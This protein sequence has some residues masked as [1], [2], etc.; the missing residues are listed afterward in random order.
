M[1]HGAEVTHL[2]AMNL[3]AEVHNH[4]NKRGKCGADMTEPGMMWQSSAPSST[5]SILAPTHQRTGIVACMHRHA[6]L[7]CN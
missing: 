5:P 6:S 7:T 2:G 4:S 1:D 3:G